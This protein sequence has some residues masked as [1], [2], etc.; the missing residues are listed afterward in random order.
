MTHRAKKSL[1]QH[2]LRSAGAIR[3]IV[4]SGDVTDKD[5]VLE[6]GPGEGVLTESLLNT[7]AK[8][9]AVEFDRSLIPILEER[10]ATQIKSGQLNL[11]EQDILKFDPESYKLKAGNYKLVANIPYY[12]TG[13]IFEK[14]LTEKTPPSCLVVLIQKE[15][16]TRIVA[17]D[18]KESILSISVKAFGTPKITMKVPASAFRPAPK[19]DSA[20]LV[21]NNV[22]QANFKGLNTDH[23]FKVVKAGFAHKRKL[24]ARNLETVAEK[25]SIQK[26]FIESDVHINA[27]AED[28]PLETWFRISRAL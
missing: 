16:A 12:I 25:E 1:G 10:F 27:R 3:M 19:V 17:R 11:V 8:V 18:K 9:I 21:V 6:I 28:V 15:V 14:F 24:L 4:S 5:I 20:I 22:S 26:A 7:G 23:F 2:F 13:A